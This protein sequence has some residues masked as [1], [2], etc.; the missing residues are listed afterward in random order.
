MRALSIKRRAT[1]KCLTGKAEGLTSK[2]GSCFREGL[3]ELTISEDTT[4]KGRP[5][6]VGRSFAF[7]SRS[8]RLPANAA[9]LKSVPILSS[10]CLRDKGG[11]RR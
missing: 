11:R 10:A 4:Q 9:S 6:A 5:I 7:L 8:F 2:A 1:K 3:R